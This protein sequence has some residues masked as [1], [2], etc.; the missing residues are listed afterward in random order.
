MKNAIVSF[1]LSN[2]SAATVKEFKAKTKE[3]FKYIT[4]GDIV[5]SFGN[6]FSDVPYDVTYAADYEIISVTAECYENGIFNDEVTAAVEFVVMTY[7][8]V[9]HCEGFLNVSNME[10]RQDIIGEYNVSMHSV[11]VYTA[12]N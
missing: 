1:D 10:W 6:A 12:E 7:R 9:Y 11:K 2:I 8:N 4:A 3:L 5:R